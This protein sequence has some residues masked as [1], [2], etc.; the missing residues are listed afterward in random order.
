MKFINCTV[1]IPVLRESDL[2]EKVVKRIIQTCQH[3]DIK[4]IIVV[5]CEKTEQDSLRSIN[6]MRMY[7]NKLNISYIVLQQDLP[8]MGG[9]IRDAMNIASGSHSIMICA[10][11]CYDP[12][13]LQ[14]FIKLSKKYPDS[15]VM[16]SR[17]LKKQKRSKDYPLYKYAWN[18]ASQHLLHILY[19]TNITD[20]TAAYW[21]Y[22]TKYFQSVN[23]T[24]T[25]HPFS[26]EQTLKYIRLGVTFHEIPFTLTGGSE[27]GFLETLSYL[28]PAIKC[29][30][31]NKEKILKPGTNISFR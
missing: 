15:I 8:G 26:L 5:I 24:E 21:M 13:Q 16:G 9:A 11:Y 28:R 31:I 6:K 14:D 17:Y 1:I 7:V 2:F 25:K 23:W 3:R 4:E 29:L 18:I 30:F 19:R 12:A 22:P 10:D 20:F 27:S